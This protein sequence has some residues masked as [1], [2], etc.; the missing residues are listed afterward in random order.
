MCR[1]E[2]IDQMPFCLAFQ[3]NSTGVGLLPL[4]TLNNKQIAALTGLAPINR[5]SGRFNGKR[6]I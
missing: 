2:C 3:T 5:D 1:Q 4:V 6:R